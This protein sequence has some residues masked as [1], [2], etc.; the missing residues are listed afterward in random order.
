MNA[1]VVTERAESAIALLNQTLGF[2]RTRAISSPSTPVSR[3]GT[4]GLDLA[5]VQRQSTLVRL[6]S[7]TEAFCGDR[8]LILAE[9]QIEPSSNTIREMMWNKASTSA[10]STWS[11]L[12]DAYK[13]WF[14]VSGVWTDINRLVE[15]R[16]AIA[17]GLGELTRMQ[18][19]KGASVRTKI[20][21]AGIKIVG[22]TL[23]L[24]EGDLERARDSCRDLIEKVDLAVTA[25]TF[26]RSI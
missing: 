26:S 2:H 3:L 24:E 23:V 14:A 12:Q 7:I 16:N 22:S 25:H 6:I 5:Q 15:A 17:H 21:A 1:V 11:A 13:D 10:V 19:S 8:L 20:A 18:K 9:T 4:T